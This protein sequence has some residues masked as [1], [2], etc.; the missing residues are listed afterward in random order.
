MAIRGWDTDAGGSLRAS[1]ASLIVILAG[2]LS[3]AAGYGTRYVAISS[4]APPSG[5]RLLTFE[6]SNGFFA[7]GYKLVLFDDGRLEYEGSGRGERPRWDEVPIEPAAMAKVRSSL[8]RLSVLPPGCCNCGGGTDQPWIFI[9]FQVSG[10]TQPRTIAHY[11][12]GACRNAPGL[13]DVENEI[14]DA[15]GTEQLVRCPLGR[16]RGS[17]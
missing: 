13:S 8:E 3:C 16:C 9:T 15:L 14:D 10:E 2:L 1:E 4:T 17:P 7:S 12:D 5:A 11:G 6:Y